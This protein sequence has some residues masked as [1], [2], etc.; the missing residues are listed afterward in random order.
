MP[1]NACH[2]QTAACDVDFKFGPGS[3]VPACMGQTIHDL[4]CSTRHVNKANHTIHRNSVWALANK[5]HNGRALDGGRY[6]TNPD[7]LDA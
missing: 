4:L 3:A 5:N 6:P 2:H 7:E 1:N